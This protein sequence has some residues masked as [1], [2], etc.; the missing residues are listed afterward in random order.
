MNQNQLF[1]VQ[2]FNFISLLAHINHERTFQR[3]D[4]NGLRKNGLPNQSKRS[5]KRPL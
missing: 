1:F 3:C 4:A 2:R 5:D